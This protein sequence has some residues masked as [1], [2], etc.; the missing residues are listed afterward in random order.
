MQAIVTD[1]G[2]RFRPDIT[3]SVPGGE[4]G[5]GFADFDMQWI[6]QGNL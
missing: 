2:V 5:E 4:H 3:I 1:H 6:E